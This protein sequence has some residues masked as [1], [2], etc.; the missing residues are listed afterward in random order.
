MKPS[1]HESIPEG[2]HHAVEL[3][4]ALVLETMR[5]RYAARAP[6]P[7]GQHPKSHGNVRAEFIVGD[8]VPRDLK[9][10]IFKTPETYSA[11]IRFSASAAP[12]RSDVK[13]DAHGMSIKVEGV[14]GKH[15]PDEHDRVDE[16][17]FMLVNHPV[18]FCRD[19]LDYADF[20]GTVAPR[21]RML[22]GFAATWRIWA[23][24]LPPS[25]AHWRLRDALNLRRTLRQ[26]VTNP[27]QIRYWSQTPY[28]LGPHAVKYSAIPRDPPPRRRPAPP[29]DNGL[30]EAMAGTLWSTDV[31]F[32]FAVQRQV[33]RESMPVEDATVLWKESQSPFRKVATIRIPA[34]QDILSDAHHPEADDLLFTPWHSLKDHQPLG[35]INRLRREVYERG[36]QYRRA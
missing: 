31:T 11:W 33:D 30:R 19:A 18:F 32:D 8:D 10:G 15:L 17:D 16:Q 14:R 29:G 22:D 7:R 9:H 35:G 28:A 36:A 13:R 2:E 1:V 26:P 4:S 34:P 20:A 3:I 12:A 6:V 23:F 5:R 25:P 27:L 21:G 24:Y